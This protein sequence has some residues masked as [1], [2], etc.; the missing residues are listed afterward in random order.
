MTDFLY[1]RLAGRYVI[2]YQAPVMLSAFSRPEPD[3]YLAH[4]PRSRYATSDP[5][6]VDLVLVCEV[7]QSSIDFDKGGKKETYA[8]AGVSEYWVLDVSARAVTVY[9]EPRPDGTFAS[10]VYHAFSDIF[11]H[12]LLG[13][14]AVDSFFPAAE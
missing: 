6:P 2:G 4:P 5:T 14:V 13:R 10:E 8:A 3:A 7:A 1:E 12:N 11:D 9:T